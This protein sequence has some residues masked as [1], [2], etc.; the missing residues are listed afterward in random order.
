MKKGI[1]AFLLALAFL[2]P[3]HAEELVSFHFQGRWSNI[4]YD[5]ETQRLTL[6]VPTPD[7]QNVQTFE[8]NKSVLTQI[9]A[10][11]SDYEASQIKSILDGR[12]TDGDEVS[13]Y[14][15]IMANLCYWDSTVNLSYKPELSELMP[16][17]RD[18]RFL[19]ILQ[20]GFC[21]WQCWDISARRKN[22][23]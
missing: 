9:L 12:D 4:S 8:L 17:I 5:E 22:F 13:D 3:C 10:G 16:F 6:N 2:L 21:L 20:I 15:E 23:Y 7:W 11:A 1:F 19:L 14:V 18:I